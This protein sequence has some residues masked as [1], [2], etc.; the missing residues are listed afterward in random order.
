M[1]TLF[2]AACALLPLAQLFA[3]K[4]V[5]VENGKPRSAVIL[6]GADAAR[7]EP[8]AEHFIRIVEASTGARIPVVTREDFAK[9]PSGTTGLFLDP[10]DFPDRPELP[11]EA[12]R[13]LPRAGNLYLFGH[14]PAGATVS[15]PLR[16]ALNHLLE[17]N[18]QVR[19]LWPGELGT[20]TPAR[21][22]FTVPEEEVSWQPP[23]LVRNLRIPLSYGYKGEKSP[24]YVRMEEEA[25]Q[26]AANHQM[27]RR[28]GIRYGHAFT[29]WWARHSK[30]HPDYFATPP[31][32]MPSPVDENSPY[33]ARSVKLR[34]S[35]RAV[36]EQIARDYEQAGAPDFYNVCPNDGVGYDLTPA[37]L[38][39]DI[40]Q[41]QPLE[42]I[43]KGTQTVQL[44]AR[45]VEFWNRLS[46][47]L[48]QINPKVTLL[49]YAYSS[50]RMP[51]PPQRPLT[52]PMMIGIVDSWDAYDSWK[53]WRDAGATL[54]LRPNWGYAAAG[55][56]FLPLR[57]IH[58]FLQFAG[59]N[60]LAGFDLDQMMGYWGTEGPLYYLLA[61]ML[62][63]PELPLE[64][65][66]E[67][68]TSAF[69]AAAPH[70]RRYLD[71]WQTRA[72]EIGTPG[73]AGGTTDT[74]P[75]YYREL[76]RSGKTSGNFLHGPYEALQYL[77]PEET[78]S[79]ALAILD[80]AEAAVVQSD[81]KAWQRVNFLKQGLEQMRLARDA[82]AL[83]H[84]IK[85]AGT[86]TDAEWQ[87][88]EKR[89]AA[90]ARYRGTLASTQV[91]WVPFI[92]Y[93]ENRYKV[94]IRPRNLPQP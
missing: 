63:N 53:G 14:R 18:L 54:F 1:K 59:R 60:G 79:P 35:N 51:P 64:T 72:E 73:G 70:I 10:A 50:Y 48:R 81:R 25:E 58:R 77:F 37:T 61:R 55:G 8:L 11:E 89:S 42:E 31:A 56:P 78:V 3:G 90:L 5:L 39:W 32:G 20:H 2:Y 27:G 68:Y 66:L 40:P 33:P 26:W 93:Y 47:R 52:G 30:D 38:E 13:I 85:N 15:E 16:W 45:Y 71:Y 49:S 75:S 76:V 17:E 44:S 41:G 74:T 80:Q 69:G 28:G 82:A 34:L 24:Q 29:H 62:E 36:I 43:W 57:E 22:E 83:G 19:F 67:E 46:A 86:A 23:L 84:Q 9:L 65:I 7:Y 12:Y 87:E 94:A 91:M 21:A 4:L 88:F 6:P 92:N